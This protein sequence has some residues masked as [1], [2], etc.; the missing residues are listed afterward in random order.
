M[1]ERISFNE[2]EE[3]LRDIDIDEEDLAEYFTAD[4]SK[5]KPFAPVLQPNP[6]TVEISEVDEFRIEGAFAMDWANGIARWRRQRRFQRRISRGDERL[7]LV[8][9]GDSWFQ[10]PIFLKDVIDRLTKNFNVWS[11]GSAGDDLKNM[12]VED[13]EYMEALEM[14]ADRFHAFMFSGGGNDIVGE[15]SGGGSY[16]EQ[17]LKPFEPGRP[18]EWYLQTQGFDER[19]A[20]IEQSL[21]HRPAKCRRDLP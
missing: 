16:L 7:V 15:K 8:S 1:P 4:P 10:F 19:L 6:E 3:K 18:A 5:S 20:F 14:H 12:V 17:M 2:L 21:P 9:E 13:P 11:V